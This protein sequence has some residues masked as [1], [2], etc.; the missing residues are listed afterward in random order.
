[1]PA[2]VGELER[3]GHP[4]PAR[5]TKLSERFCA[6][7]AGQKRDFRVLVP[8]AVTYLREIARYE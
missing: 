8:E 3:C 4:L 2:I 1:M 5:L 7:L 6:E